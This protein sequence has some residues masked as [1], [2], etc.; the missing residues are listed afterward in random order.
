MK[1]RGWFRTMTTGFKRLGRLVAFPF[2]WLCLAL[3]LTGC[4][5]TATEPTAPAATGVVKRAVC[6]GLTKVDANKYGGWAGDC[7]GCDVDLQVF[8]QLCKEQGLDTV[9]LYNA[10]ATV[11]GASDALRKAI[12]GAGPGSLL[13]LYWSGHGGQVRDTSGDEAD[14]MDETLV[15]WDGQLVDDKLGDILDTV[16][17]GV[18]VFFVSDTCHSG[19]NFRAKK[20]VVPVKRSFRAALIHY[21]GAADGRFS[22]GSKQGGVFTTA[23]IDSW[24]DGV[25]YLDWFRLAAKLVDTSEHV[26]VYVEYGA[27]TDEFRNA[28]VFK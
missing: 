8:S 7:P 6:V 19:T 5:T 10:Q 27:V 14:G 21:A 23:L 1:A 24:R 22:L 17:A 26:P 18:R 15:A 4:R 28:G 16:P 11:K 13:V 3:L 20:R 12:A 2:G 25:T 9:T